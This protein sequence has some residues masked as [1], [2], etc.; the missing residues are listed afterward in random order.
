[1]NALSAASSG[2]D[3]PHTEQWPFGVSR[4]PTMSIGTA[5]SILTQEFPTVR[6]SK[7]R[8]LEEQGI[9]T[10]HRTPSGYRTYSQ[11]DVERL[12][13]A[14]AAQR[15]SF[16]PLKV[17][18]ERLRELDR[19]GAG[20]PAPGARVV[21]EDGE[22]T[23]AATRTRMSIAQLA[24]AAGLEATFVAELAEAGI[25]VADR[26]RRYGPGVLPV[27]S[28]AASLAEYGVAPRHLRTLRIAAD[29]QV[30]LIE[31]ITAPIRSHRTR[32]SAEAAAQAQAGEL[33]QVLTRLHAALVTDGI[34]R[35]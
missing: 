5:L 31:Q 32:G 13:F 18:R 10:P 22:L 8:F 17:I 12:R 15:D 20:A 25:I 9:V 11:A 19:A 24:E 1:M 35:L 4:T 34:E 6:I 33:A 2:A 27:V 26:G 29:R 16:L 23:A 21:T 7:I 30:D 3:D 28:E 14:L